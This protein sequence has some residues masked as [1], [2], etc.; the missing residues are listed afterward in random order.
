MSVILL[1]AALGLVIAFVASASMDYPAL[2][3][4][5]ALGAIACGISAAALWPDAP[6]PPPLPKP[7]MARVADGEHFT[8]WHDDVRGV[9]CWYTERGV[10][11]GWAP[12]LSCLP[13]S[14]LAP[15]AEKPSPEPKEPP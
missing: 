12:A 5:A 10:H 13:D 15:R 9:T 6:Q 8:I 3:G 1:L 14:Q 7:G 4:F 11:G 2:S